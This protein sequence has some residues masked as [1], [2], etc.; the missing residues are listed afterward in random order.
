M[1]VRFAVL[2]AAIACSCRP[3]SRNSRPVLPP[4]GRRRCGRL[5]SIPIAG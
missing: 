5:K 4:A 2:M 1:K 3:G